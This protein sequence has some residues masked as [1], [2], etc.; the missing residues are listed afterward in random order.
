MWPWRELWKSGKYCPHLTDRGRDAERVHDGAGHLP[1][2][3]H[4]P[5]ATAFHFL[6]AAG[7]LL[8]LVEVTVGAGARDEAWGC[9]RFPFKA[10]SDFH[11]CHQ[12]QSWEEAA[13]RNLV[14]P[15]TQGTQV[16]SVRLLEG[17]F[18]FSSSSTYSV[19]L[20]FM[21]RLVVRSKERSF[22]GGAQKN[23]GGITVP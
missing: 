3:C 20:S 7:L 1:S 6:C 16:G 15:P 19:F 21:L 5:A 22:W 8:V 2:V 12:A 13:C 14:L 18:G 17:C 4:Q 11:S 9:R 10:T 23:Q